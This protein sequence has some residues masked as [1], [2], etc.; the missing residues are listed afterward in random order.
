MSEKNE[1][2]FRENTR[3]LVPCRGVKFTPLIAFE[4]CRQ[5]EFYGGLKQLKPAQNNLPPIEVIVCKVPVTVRVQ[6]FVEDDIP[7]KGKAPKAGGE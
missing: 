4:K 6:Y 2:V 7:N 1:T 5:C 3:K